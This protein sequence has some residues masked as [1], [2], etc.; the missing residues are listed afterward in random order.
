MH[1]KERKNYNVTHMKLF[2]MRAPTGKCA[3]LG[4]WPGPLHVGKPPQGHT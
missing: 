3:C 2:I 4:E 1:N